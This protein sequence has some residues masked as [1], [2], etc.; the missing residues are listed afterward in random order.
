MWLAASDDNDNKASFMHGQILKNLQK[1]LWFYFYSYN[2]FNNEGIILV[3]QRKNKLKI[4]SGKPLLARKKYLIYF[5]CSTQISKL[6]FSSAR[7][8]SKSTGLKVGKAQI[9]PFSPELSNNFVKTVSWIIA[10]PFFGTQS[11]PRITLKS[12]FFCRQPV[13]ERKQKRPTKG[14]PSRLW[15]AEKFAWY[16]EANIEDIN[17]KYCCF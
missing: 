1:N 5:N 4:I 9:C 6:I 17:D 14:E 13:H 3:E 11:W 7:Q 16:P 12:T 15:V 2:Y 10:T 8:C